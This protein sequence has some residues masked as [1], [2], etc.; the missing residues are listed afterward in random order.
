MTVSETLFLKRCRDAGFRAEADPDSPGSY[1]FYSKETS[2]AGEFWHDT[3]GVWQVRF[4][5]PRFPEAPQGAGTG[6]RLSSEAPDYWWQIAEEDT[7]LARDEAA[8]SDPFAEDEAFNP[9]K[10][11]EGKTEAERIARVRVGQA[12]YRKRLEAIW[13]GACAVTG[14]T[15][16]EL[17]RASHAKAWAECK[18][19]RER[20][21][22]FN[23]LLLVANLDALFDKRL[24]SFD[25]A[26]EILINPELDLEA[27][28]KAGVHP[29][30]RLRKL[31][32]GHVPFL[33][34]HRAKFFEKEKVGDE[35]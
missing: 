33:A 12:K 35:L 3:R 32:P 21:S 20:L 11:E 6:T 28:E 29:G 19:G 16:P 25:E 8:T 9:E 13:E 17:L 34:W 10:D 26:G 15:I 7:R 22:G 27:L 14:V 30:M 31:L 2:L 24:I 23:G 4:N 5:R 18:T 1:R